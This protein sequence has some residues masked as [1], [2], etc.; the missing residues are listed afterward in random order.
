[1]HMQHPSLSSSAIP[2]LVAGLLLL[3]G[4]NSNTQANLQTQSSAPAASSLSTMPLTVAIHAFADQV[5]ANGYD[6]DA[7]GQAISQP[8]FSVAG[9]EVHIAG[10]TVQVYAYAS[11]DDAQKDAQKISADGSAIGESQVSWVGSPHFFTKEN[12]IVLYIGDNT[13][14]IAALQQTLGPQIAGKSSASTG[15]GLSL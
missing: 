2:A 10:E 9:S 15:T 8:F 14:A 5:K 7:S 4:C 12:L 11:K 3:S 13:T 6:A 1:M